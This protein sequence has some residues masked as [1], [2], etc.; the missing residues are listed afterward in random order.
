MSTLRK[1]RTPATADRK[2]GGVALMRRPP[3]HPGGFFRE[4]REGQPDLVTQRDAAARLGVSV[5]HLFE[6]ENGR[7]PVSVAIALKLEALTG[8]SAEQWLTLQ[9]RHDLWR[10]LQEPTTAIPG[11]PFKTAKA[12][13]R[14]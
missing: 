14:R 2:T 13:R 4:I 11:E 5:K 12:S 9:M 8:V 1:R 7:K 3:L 6:V 10:A